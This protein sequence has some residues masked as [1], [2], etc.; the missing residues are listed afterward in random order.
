[1]E[2][3]KENLLVQ[4]PYK[5]VYKSGNSIVK[6]FAMTHPKSAVFNE[7]LITARVEETGLPISKLKEVTQIDG[8]W[9]LVIEYKAGKTMQEL[10]QEAKEKNDGSLENLMEEF[11]D[12]QLLV[13]SKTAPMLPSLKEKLYGQ[14]DGL[15]TLDAT[16]R[17][18]L[19]TRLE[20]MPTHQ[21]VCHGDFNPSNVIVDEDGNLSII[22]WAHATQG[23]ASADAAMTYLLFALEDE[24]MANMYMNLFC[25]KS[26]TAKQYVQ[27]W[28]PIVAASQLEKEHAMEKDFLM[29]WI[30]VGSSG[31]F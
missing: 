1:M 12:L 22:D 2:L 3:K 25:K 21:K 4:R 10:M 24:D 13:H 31:V 11:V 27:Q 17:Y 18:D 20:S 8:K 5:E 15:K 23:N 7:A 6:V 14:I 9:S 29:R 28:L 26:D 19:L 30:N 16:Q